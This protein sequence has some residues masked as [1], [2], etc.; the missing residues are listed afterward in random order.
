MSEEKRPIAISLNSSLD[1]THSKEQ[2]IY[3]SDVASLEPVRTAVAVKVNKM[4]L[5]K[6]LENTLDLFDEYSLEDEDKCFGN[7]LRS[8]NVGNP[9]NMYIPM[10]ITMSYL[11][12]TGSNPFHLN[13]YI[14][15]FGKVSLIVASTW[16]F[17]KFYFGAASYLAHH[18][19]EADKSIIN[20]K[21]LLHSQAVT[22]TNDLKYPE[23]DLL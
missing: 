19:L 14:N 20:A 22:I 16:L 18:N 4:L 1:K 12:L 21:A 8:V 3:P 9:I 7:A 2:S 5:L 23:S 11:K 15:N 10:L 13:S 6:N 17:W